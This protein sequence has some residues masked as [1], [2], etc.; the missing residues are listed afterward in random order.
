[1][2]LGYLIGNRNIES[3]TS[4]LPPSSLLFKIELKQTLKGPTGQIRSVQDWFNR[5]FHVVSTYFAIY[6]KFFI[7]SL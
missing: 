7:L 5:N 3:T 4:H 2:R 1:M 6:F